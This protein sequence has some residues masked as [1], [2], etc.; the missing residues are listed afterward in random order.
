LVRFLL[1]SSLF[2]FGCAG[3]VANGPLF[4]KHKAPLEN[5]AL[6]YVYKP[7]SGDGIT[8]CLKVLLNEV[9]YG[10]L[11]GEGF[12]KAVVPPGQYN[13]VLQTDAFMGP[14]IIEHQFRA[15]ASKTYYYEFL[16]TAGKIPDGAVETKHIGFG[17][18]SGNVIAAGSGTHALIKSNE[19][20][21]IN[22]LK[23]LKKSL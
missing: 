11:K 3:P 17:V 21:A 8:A 15:E 10:C 9:N 7:K 14:R 6:I 4:T 23:S 22:V 19:I 16:F 18:A 5:K 20:Q 13:L 12:V 1:L 2:L